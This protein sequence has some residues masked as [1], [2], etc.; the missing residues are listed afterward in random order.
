MEQDVGKGY[1][2]ARRESNLKHVLCAQLSHPPYHPIASQSISQD[3][4]LTPAVTTPSPTFRESAGVVS[5]AHI[6]RPS[7]T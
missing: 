1:S 3:V 4:P 6:K 5:I 7:L 2:Y